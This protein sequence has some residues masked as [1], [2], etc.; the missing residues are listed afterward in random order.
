MKYSLIKEELPRTRL[1][2]IQRFKLAELYEN[3]VK[4]DKNV[5]QPKFEEYV[6]IKSFIESQV[7]M[8]ISP[9]DHLE[10]DIALDSLGKI[11][12]IDFIERTFGVKI[13][14]D[15][16][17][18]FP[19]IIKLVDHIRE[20][21]VFH[22][23][24]MPDWS[25]ILKEKIP[26]KLPKS[27]PTLPFFI[28][29]SRNFLKL[30]F[31]FRSKGHNDLPDGP[32]IIAPNHQ[33]YFD[34]LFVTAHLKRKTI[35][36]TF[37]YAK[38]KHVKTKLAQFLARKNNVI[39]MDLNSDLKESIQK[40]AAVLKSGK[41]VMIFPEGTRSKTGELGEFKKTFAILSKELNVTV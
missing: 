21:K 31:N 29:S 14:E 17:L 33:S 27:W 3:P 19:S 2:K 12:L 16:L 28:K 37:F 18:K 6:A 8:T 10:F 22:N 40:L 4:K 41:K 38:R 24:E 1:G 15:N 25:E 32:A 5:N 13:E 7:D 30:Y 9:D 39:V 11:T 36:E 26:L 20:N 35:K 23:L 34:A